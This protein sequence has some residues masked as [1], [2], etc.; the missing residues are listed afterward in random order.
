MW[1]LLQDGK[2]A[3]QKIK[4]KKRTEKTEKK[5]KTRANSFFV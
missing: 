4:Q 1:Y 2:M 3:R 5:A